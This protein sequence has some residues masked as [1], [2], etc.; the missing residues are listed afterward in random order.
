MNIMHYF[1]RTLY[2]IVPRENM[3]TP[4]TTFD[5]EFDLTER[6]LD[7]VVIRET[8]KKDKCFIWDKN[9]QTKSYNRFV[10]SKNSQSKKVCEITFYKSGQTNKYLPRPTFK[11]I[12]NK[13]EDKESKKVIIAFGESSDAIIFWNLINFINSYKELVDTGAF[14]Q[15][16]K[17]IQKNTYIIEFQNKTEKQKIEDLKELIGIA[18]LS[19]SDLKALTFESRKQNLKAF[20]FLLKNSIVRGN[21]SHDWYREKY[22]LPDGEEYI[23][24]HFLKRNDWILGLN[25]DIRFIC[26]FLDEQKI[27]LEDSQ[28]KGSP[29][30]DLLGVSD[31]TTLVELKHPS[32]DIFKKTKSKGRA[33]TWDF[34]ADFIEGISQ[35]LGQKFEL[36][37]MFDQKPFIK[38]DGTFLDKNEI[39]SIDPKTI[40]LIGNKKREF[41]TRDQIHEHSVKNKTLQRFRRNN[42][43]IDV[44]T[45]DELFERA[46][47]VVYSRKLSSEWYWQELNEIFE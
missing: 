40:L 45:F 13:D 3:I 47:Q 27:G 15:S 1:S 44:L 37:K 31:F 30:T 6:S 7:E 42:R 5:N 29:K 32:T 9:D 18:D 2:A 10:I 19:T 39:Q 41:P 16:F 4:Q 8:Y 21:K 17:V 24:H 33:N 34:T 43:N 11:R 23:W 14:E 38:E 28:G 26:D 25:L 35:C 22:K 36:D 12:S 20:Y 46:F